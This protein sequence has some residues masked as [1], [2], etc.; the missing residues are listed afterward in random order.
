MP[1]NSRLQNPIALGSDFLADCTQHTFRRGG[2]CVVGAHN[3]RPAAMN[4]SRTPCSWRSALLV[5]ALV[6]LIVLS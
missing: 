1:A 2:D 6:S 4:S 5:L 3:G